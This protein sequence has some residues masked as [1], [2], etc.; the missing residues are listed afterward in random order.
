VGLDQASLLPSTTYCH[1]RAWIIFVLLGKGLIV[2][3]LKGCACV[4]QEEEG[5]VEAT[6]QGRGES[7]AGED[8]KS[9]VHVH[10]HAPAEG[11]FTGGG[12]KERGAGP[13]V[14]GRQQESALDSAQFQGLLSEVMSPNHHLY[15]CACVHGSPRPR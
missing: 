7:G 4:I 9:D 13:E 6:M 14:G 12:I 15:H 5:L 10:I 11:P 1:F 3:G 8:V 2:G